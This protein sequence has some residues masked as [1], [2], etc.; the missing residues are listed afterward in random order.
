MS[1]NKE[2]ILQ[3][4]TDAQTR[5]DLQ[6]MFAKYLWKQW[7]VSQHMKTLWSLS[8]EE[9]KEQGAFLWWLKKEI[10]RVYWERDS[11]FVSQEVAERLA[12][13]TVDWSVG[14]S[15]EIWYYSLL[16]HMRHHVEKVCVSMG[17]DIQYGH[18]VVSKYE[19]FQSVNI[20][21]THPATEMH[22]T[23]YLS[24]KD[25]FWESLVMRTQTS[26]HQVQYLR[27]HGADTRMCVL[28]RV[29]RNEK[30]DATHDTMF[31][32][33]EWLVVDKWLSFSHLKWFLEEFLSLLLQ[34]EVETRLRPAYFPFVEPWVEID[35]RIKWE[36]K[37]MELLW[38]WMVHPHVLREGGLD[39]KEY[40]WF[41]FWVWMTRLAALKYNLKDIRLMTNGDLRFGQSQPL[42]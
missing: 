4:L 20:P 42:W 15:P 6:E 13:D 18:E 17:M 2:R 8:P 10:T 40:S 31:R 23:M 5:E 29:Y 37:R 27:E 22:D 26:A 1:L 38:A 41:A 14:T 21:L 30:M 32:Q 9:K 7:I 3:E 24:Q 12:Q 39:E 35:A 33:I 34:K 36:E 11:F 28:G 16:M 19:N 25:D